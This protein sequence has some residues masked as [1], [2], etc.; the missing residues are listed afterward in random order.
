MAGPPAGARRP[1]SATGTIPQANQ[2]ALYSSPTVSSATGDFALQN[3]QSSSGTQSTTDNAT[4]SYPGQRRGGRCGPGDQLDR[5][6]HRQ[7][8]RSQLARQ[9]GDQHRLGDGRQLRRPAIAAAATAPCC[10]TRNFDL[11]LDRLHLGGRGPGQTVWWR[12]RPS[13]CRAT[14][15][16]PCRR[17]TPPPTA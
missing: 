3:V 17:P 4:T 16:W 15:T 1:N 8:R 6:H 7:H 5:D 9:P 11:D 14:P 12:T 2:G 13:M 10:P